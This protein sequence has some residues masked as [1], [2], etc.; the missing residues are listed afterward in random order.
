MRTAVQVQWH[1]G[2]W[3]MPGLKTTL[4]CLGLGM[5]AQFEVDAIAPSSLLICFAGEGSQ[6]ASWRR[7][8]KEQE[9]F[10]GSFFPNASG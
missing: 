3:P 1:Y 10:C 8:Q 7:R 2:C 6:E 5:G 4:W 9:M